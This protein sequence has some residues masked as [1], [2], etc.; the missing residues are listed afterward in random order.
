MQYT[1]TSRKAGSNTTRNETAMNEKQK[2]LVQ[3]F[4]ALGSL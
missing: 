3:K 1:T 2:D 4:A